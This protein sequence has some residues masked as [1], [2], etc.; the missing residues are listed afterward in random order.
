MGHKSWSFNDGN[1]IPRQLLRVAFLSSVYRLCSEHH[2][3][4][5]VVRMPPHRVGCRL[6]SLRSPRS[7]AS[8][9]VPFFVPVQVRRACQVEKSSESVGVE[10]IGYSRLRR[11]TLHGVRQTLWVRTTGSWIN[12]VQGTASRTADAKCLV[13]GG[14][15]PAI[16]IPTPEATLYPI[17][18]LVTA[19]GK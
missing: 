3:V 5:M 1:F 19:L 12:L 15:R 2:V 6:D 16:D 11:F 8:C 7:T 14:F 9:G 10:R 4:L 18:R 17:P 13:C